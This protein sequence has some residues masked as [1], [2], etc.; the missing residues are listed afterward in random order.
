M[1][2]NVT[3][4]FWSF[5]INNYSP[6]QLQL[7]RQ[8]YPD[9]CREIVHTLEEGEEGTP[10]IQGFI[11][12]LRQ[13]RFSFVKKLFPCAH[14]R[15]LTSAEYVENTK[16]YAQKQDETAVSASVHRFNDPLHTLEGVVKKVMFYMIEKYEGDFGTLYKSRK[17]IHD[18]TLLRYSAEKEMVKSDYKLAKIFVSA[19]YE[20][21]W[22]HFGAQMFENLLD[23]YQKNETHT[24]THTQD[25][26]FSQ[27][28]DIPT[29]DAAAEGNEASGDEDSEDSGE[30]DEG[31]YFEDS[32]SE[33]D[34]GYSEGSGDD[35]G[36]E[37]DS[38]SS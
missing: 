13:Q 12:L 35:D 38:R 16:Q 14:I 29:T 24:H 21:M 27:E 23:V 8:G 15:P 7:V 33:T 4:A 28:V 37:D 34:E 6:A 10:H 26:I 9:Y 32:G 5:T 25:E 2:T 3:T 36:E 18:F 19:T 11:K 20:R 31:S 1:T 17:S 30:E 22:K